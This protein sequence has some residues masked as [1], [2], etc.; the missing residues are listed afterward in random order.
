MIPVLLDLKFI[1]IYTFGVFLVLAFFWGMFMLWRNIKLTSYKEEDVFDILFSA[2]FG[3][4]LF[5]RLFFVLFNFSKFGFSLLKFILINGYPGMSL[6][7]SLAGGFLFFYLVS[8]RKKIPGEILVDYFIPPL[9]I[10]L[11]V[12]KIGSFLSGVDVGTKT[13]L[14]I[15]VRYLGYTGNRHITAIFESLLFFVLAYFSYRIMLSVRKGNLF[16]GY[17]FLFFI[18]SFALTNLLLDKLKENHLYFAGRSVNYSL[19][20]LLFFAT[21]GYFVYYFRKQIIE[22]FITAK[23]TFTSYVKK[24]YQKSTGGTAKKTSS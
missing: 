4:I 15:A 19:S 21:G 7:G 23:N 16:H 2:L 1:K 24:T 13:K 18:F 9:F 8:S 3:A 17:G 6:Y 20:V 14:I 5:G 22:F 12:G 10:S 11:G